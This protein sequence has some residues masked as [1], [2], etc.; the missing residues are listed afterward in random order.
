MVPGFVVRQGLEMIFLLGYPVCISEG[1]LDERLLAP[2]GSGVP[3]ESVPI[4][5]P[6][7]T[8]DGVTNPPKSGTASG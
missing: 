3:A 7:N 4:A 5:E 8:I 1:S 2:G 6:A